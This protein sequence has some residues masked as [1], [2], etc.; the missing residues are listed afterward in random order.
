MGERPE[1]EQ[2]G[3]P[4]T[5]EQRRKLRGI[6]DDLRVQG[7]LRRTDVSDHEAMMN[8]VRGRRADNAP[9]GSVPADAARLHVSDHQEMLDTLRG[10]STTNK[11]KRPKAPRRFHVSE[12]TGGFT[13]TTED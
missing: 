10:F 4:M 11:P 12:Q 1:A 9:L 8:V 3:D 6:L 5:P 2:R 13:L 7:E